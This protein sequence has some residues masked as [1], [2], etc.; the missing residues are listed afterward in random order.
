MSTENRLK[1]QRVGGGCGAAVRLRALHAVRRSRRIRNHVQNIVKKAVSLGVTISSV[2]WS[3][4]GKILTPAPPAV[5]V[6]E[7][8][9]APVPVA[10]VDV[11]SD[12]LLSHDALP[13]HQ[14]KNE[15]SR[16]DIENKKEIEMKDL[17]LHKSPVAPRKNDMGTFRGHR[18][19]AS[20]LAQAMQNLHTMPD[21]KEKSGGGLSLVKKPENAGQ[22]PRNIEK[23]RENMEQRRLDRG[24]FDPR[25]LGDRGFP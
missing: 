5:V 8:R 2:L 18:T 23:M 25:I 17:L 24:R 21:E 20:G 7:S 13:V 11:V 10:S 1:N 3:V 22:E 12:D 9:P 16:Q 14:I 4:L 19:V 15:I 6:S